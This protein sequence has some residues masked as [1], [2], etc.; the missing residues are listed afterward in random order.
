MA[1]KPLVQPWTPEETTL[2]A[3][4][5]RDGEEDRKKGQHPGVSSTGR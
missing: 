1:R 2:L 3:K 5:L 4:L